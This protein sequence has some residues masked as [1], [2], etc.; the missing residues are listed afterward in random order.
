MNYCSQVPVTFCCCKVHFTTVDEDCTYGTFLLV[1]S[2]HK[3]QSYSSIANISPTPL[4]MCLCAFFVNA[5]IK[6][7]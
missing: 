5:R 1:S 2:T 3:I 6:Y 4:E 7:G